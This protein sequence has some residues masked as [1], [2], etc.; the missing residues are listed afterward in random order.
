[1]SKSIKKCPCCNSTNIRKDFDYPKTM[2]CCNKCGA[3]FDIYGEITFDPRE[4]EESK[5][6]IGTQRSPFGLGS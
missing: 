5:P 6:R 2:R 3:D 4:L 1:M